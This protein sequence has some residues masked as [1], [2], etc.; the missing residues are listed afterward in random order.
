M[1]RLIS[2]SLN[3]MMVAPVIGLWDLVLALVVSA[4]LCTLLARVYIFT[5][6]GHSYSRSFVHTQVIVGVTISLIMLIIGSNI[7]R[8]FALVGALSIIRFRNPVKDSRDVAFILMSMAI[9]MAAGTKFYWFAAIFTLFISFL[10]GMFHYFKFGDAGVAF[11]VLRLRMNA[12]HRADIEAV[13]ADSCT[14][15]SLVSLDRFADAGDHDDF[16]YEINLRRG[17]T[18]EELIGRLGA[19]SPGSSIS[20]LVGEASVN[21]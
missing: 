7:A 13:F 4:V 8:A 16:V 1:D 6:S 14:D 9:G 20:L 11:Y 21:V 19:V 3:E 12:T 15:Y 18:Y 2:E 10:L 17:V 5:H